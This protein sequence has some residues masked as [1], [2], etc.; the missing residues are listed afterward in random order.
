MI[1]RSQSVSILAVLA[2][3]ALSG[4]A[5]DDTV[6]RILVGSSNYTFFNCDDLA[7]TIKAKEARERELQGLMAKSSAGPAGGV[8]NVIAYRPDYQ[9]NHGELV[10]ARSAAAEK[11]CLPPKP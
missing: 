9:E 1:L 7:G 10:R 6:G 8:V 2:A 3:L 5:S 11:N 4:C